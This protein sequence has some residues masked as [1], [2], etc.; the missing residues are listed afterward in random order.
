MK[1]INA[2]KLYL[3]EADFRARIPDLAAVLS[4]RGPIR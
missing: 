1:R 2:T 3:P 4:R